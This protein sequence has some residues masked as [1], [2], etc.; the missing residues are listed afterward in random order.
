MIFLTIFPILSCIVVMGTSNENDMKFFTNFVTRMVLD[1][2]CHVGVIAEDLKNNSRATI[3]TNALRESE[4][5]VTVGDKIENNRIQIKTCHL[6]III[7]T[8]DIYL[9]QLDFSHKEIIY[10]LSCLNFFHKKD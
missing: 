3:L 8:S 9:A 10:V 2:D 4:Y 1:Q 7:I 6:D 5:P